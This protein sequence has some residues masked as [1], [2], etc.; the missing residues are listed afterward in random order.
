[1]YCSTKVTNGSRGSG[2]STRGA[3]QAEES[4]QLIKF[5]RVIGHYFSRSGEV[6]WG[7]GIARRTA[8]WPGSPPAGVSG[9]FSGPKPLAP[10]WVFAFD[11]QAFPLLFRWARTSLLGVTWVKTGPGYSFLYPA[12]SVPYPTQS[13]FMAVEGTLWSFAPKQ[14]KKN[15]GKANNTICRT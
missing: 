9:P 13:T 8:F 6:R 15:T 10:L 3:Q 2:W 12:S 5:R 4:F 11:I 14:E 1:M 7:Q